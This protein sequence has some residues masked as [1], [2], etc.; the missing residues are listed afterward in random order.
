MKKLLPA[1]VLAALTGVNG[2]QAVHVNSDG[3]G[4]VLLYPFYTVEGSQDTYIQL[5]NTTMAY[6]AVKV[7]IL[8]SMN[9]QEVLDFNLYLSPYDHWSAIITADADGDG[10]VIRSGDNSCTVPL[11]ISNGTAVEFRNFEFLNDSVNGLDR[12]RE[13]YVEVIEMAEVVI[14]S[15]DWPAD[16]LHDSD[17]VP[18]NCQD[19]DTSWAPGG[20]W[21]ADNTDGMDPAA[22]GLYGYGVIINV[23]EGTA[24]AYDAV[25]LDAFWDPLIGFLH[26]DPGDLTPALAQSTLDYDILDGIT[27]ESGTA[28]EGIDAVSAVMMHDTVSN[29]YVLEPS[30][31]AGTDWVLTMPTKREYVDRADTDPIDPPFESFWDPTVSQACEDFLLT[32]YDREELEPTAPPGQ[33]DFSPL[34]PTITTLN[35]VLCYE[36][37]VLTFN[38]SEV[39][40]GSARTQTDLTL[41]PGFDNGWAVIDFTVGSTRATLDANAASGDLYGLP[42]IGFAVQRYINGDLDG[43]RANYAGSIEHKYSRQFGAPVVP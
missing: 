25:A 35:P 30:I 22:G 39:L 33:N 14:G 5:V 43:V 41:E 7:R 6:K 13:G 21:S 16:I 19:L 23:D 18:G 4:Q 32:Y 42:V 9:S 29:D 12:T 2:A 38:T 34:P 1:A 24:A 10:G 27:V 11:A 36:A 8:E 3:L 37:N 15:Q 31:G 40:N 28:D 26:T 17:G 20:V